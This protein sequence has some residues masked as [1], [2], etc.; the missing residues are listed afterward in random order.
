MDQIEF[1]RPEGLLLSPAFS[2]VAVIPPGATTI[3]VGGID[4]TTADGTLVG[5]GDIGAQ[6]EQVL[7]NLRIALE[8]AGASMQDLVSWQLFVVDGV[9]LTEGYQAAAAHLP[10]DRE[11]PLITVAI[12]PK[13]GVPGALLELSAVAAVVR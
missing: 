9:D 6:T 3:H 2:W 10:K 8:A 7:T 1:L 12:V 11:P 5:E 4:A 13:L